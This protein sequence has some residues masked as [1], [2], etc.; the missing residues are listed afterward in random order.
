[1][2]TAQGAHWLSDVVTGVLFGTSMAV[3]AFALVDEIRH[4]ALRRRQTGADAG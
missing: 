3:L 2:A 4:A 1:M